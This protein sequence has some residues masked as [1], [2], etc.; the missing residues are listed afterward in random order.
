MKRLFFILLVLVFMSA[1]AMAQTWYNANQATFAWDAVTTLVGGAAIPAG[2]TVK[3]Q[4]YRKLS[5]ATVGEKVGNE[6]STPSAL[7]SFT[8]EGSYFVGAEALRYVGTT[9]VSRS[10]IS[11]SDVPANCQGGAAFGFQYW[12]ALAA[13]TAYRPVP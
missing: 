8:S 5:P 7:V 1:P 12:L 13:P 9:L 2:S 3:Y 10:T 6:V 4:A 11:Y